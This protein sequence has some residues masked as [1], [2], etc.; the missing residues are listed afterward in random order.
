MAVFPIG[1][2]IVPPIVSSYL[3][4]NADSTALRMHAIGRTPLEP[5]WVVPLWITKVIVLLFLM[6]VKGNSKSNKYGDDP[7]F[8]SDTFPV[9]VLSEKMSDKFSA[10]F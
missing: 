1:L 6:I 5:D 2:V 8:H 7:I 4:M 3:V 10:N 9:A